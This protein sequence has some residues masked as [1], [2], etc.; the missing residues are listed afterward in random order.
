MIAIRQ[1]KPAGFLRFSAYIQIYPLEYSN[2]LC[3]YAYR[4]CS[5]LVGTTGFQVGP[6]N[7]MKGI[8]M[9]SLVPAFYAQFRVGAGG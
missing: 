1:V 4:R 6:K 9:K 7:P 2:I 8:S 5:I 3:Y